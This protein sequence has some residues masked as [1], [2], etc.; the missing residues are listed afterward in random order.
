MK[1]LV[2]FCKENKKYSN[3]PKRIENSFKKIAQKQ[4]Y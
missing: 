2:L 1:A 4:S 3:N